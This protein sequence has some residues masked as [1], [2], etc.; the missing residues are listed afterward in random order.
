VQVAD[1]VL[2][3]ALADAELPHF[4]VLGNGLDRVLALLEGE[5]ELRRAHRMLELGTP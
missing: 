3:Q 1:L 2:E 5:L 4:F